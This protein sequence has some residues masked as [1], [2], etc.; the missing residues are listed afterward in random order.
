MLFFSINK[1]FGICLLGLIY[2]KFYSIWMSKKV[3]KKVTIGEDQRE[4]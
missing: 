2:N 3:N 1:L 4:K